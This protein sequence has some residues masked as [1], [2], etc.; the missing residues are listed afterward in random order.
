MELFFNIGVGHFYIGNY[1]LA[2][3]KLII[4]TLPWLL[5][6]ILILKRKINLDDNKLKFNELPI[7]FYLIWVFWWLYDFIY[8][9][10]GKFKD[11]NNVSLI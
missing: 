9:I 6:A 11:E 10:N 8:V 3:I 2:R 5:F 1:K 7:I 4:L